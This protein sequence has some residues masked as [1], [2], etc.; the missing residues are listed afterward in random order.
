M[1]LKF[2]LM[3]LLFSMS[4]VKAQETETLK[5]GLNAP[6]KVIDSLFRE[7]QFYASIS[8][9]LLQNKPAG[10]KQ[11]SFSTGIALGFLRDIP[12]SK[13]RDWSVALGL[14]Y[15]YNNIKHNVQV[16][17]ADP[18]VYV[19]EN[20]YD[21][22]KLVLHYIDIPLEIR[23]RNATPLNHKFWRIYT[24]FKASY[25]IGSK[26][27]FQSSSANYKIKN[28]N[29]VNKWQFGPYISFGYNTVNMYAYY[30]LTP[31]FKDVKIEDQDLKMSSFN[32]G[33]MFY[34]L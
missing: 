14:G 7:D 30:G 3:I 10:Y 13:S 26:T 32:I 9:N 5:E 4:L 22:N 11:Y 31:I 27:D 12:F 6:Y 2:L 23:W 16:Q 15:S 21:K 24:G 34:I 17:N 29:D 18:N 28:S 33:F 20:S 19:I 1:K 25:L 8:Y